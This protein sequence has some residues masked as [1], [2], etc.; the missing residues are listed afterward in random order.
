MILRSLALAAVATATFSAETAM[1][2]NGSVDYFTRSRAAALPQM[3]ST[4]DRAYYGSLFEAI[5]ARNWD[6][7]EVMLAGRTDGPLHGAALASYYLHPESPRIELPRIE[8][9]LARYADLPEAEA[10]V[11][12]GQ[13]RGL[14]NPPR[15]RA[16]RNLVRQPGMTK[17]IRPRAVQDGT[18]PESVKSAILERITNDDPDGARL[19]LDGVDATLS[20]QARAEWRYRVAWSYYIENRDAQAWALAD[21][22]RDGGSGAWVAEGDW[23]AGL[24]AWRLGDCERAA[25]AFQRSAAGAVNPELGAAAH[26]WASRALIRCRMP[27]QADEQLR[28]AARFPETLYGMLAHEQMGRDL[29]PTHTEPDL[30]ADDWRRLQDEQAVRQAVMLAEIGQREQ[31]ENDILWL[32]RTGDPDD[33]GALARL[34]RALGL[35]GAQNYMAYNAPRGEAAH[36]SLRYPVTFRAP[37]GGWRVDPALAF[38]HALQESNFRERVVSPAGAIGLMQ[39]MPITRR[40]YAASINM[41]AGAD[42]KDPAVNLAFG[43]RTLEALGSANYTQG[44][45]PKVMAAYNA[46]PSPVMRWESEIRDQDDP[47][48]W[49]ESIPYWETRGYVAI[50]MRNYWMYLRQANALAPSRTDLAENDWPLFPRVR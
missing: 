28:G 48:L 27:E 5:D 34:A 18:M 3:L 13:T 15:L 31:A 6:R 8:A 21:T 1:A 10:M 30:T 25:E 29:P 11:R 7:V 17:R 45:L 49:M 24:A 12:L 23:A 4:D 44:K 42:L 32:V 41:S 36:P 16:E 43:Q 19:L 47:L 50:V 40:E 33:F 26:Y 37:V 35:T 46:G 38:A 22:V 39:I 9:W 2:Q 20:P 14:E